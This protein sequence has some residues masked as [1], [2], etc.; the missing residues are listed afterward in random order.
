MT[1]R[2][3]V[4]LLSTASLFYSGGSGGGEVCYHGAVKYYKANR[5]PKFNKKWNFTYSL[6]LHSTFFLQNIF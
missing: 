5:T 6:L 3:L 2:R 4:S 1:I